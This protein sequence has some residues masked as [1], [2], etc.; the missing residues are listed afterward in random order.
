M[1]RVRSRPRAPRAPAPDESSAGNQEETQA[2]AAGDPKLC[3][4]P[5]GPHAE[6]GKFVAFPQPEPAGKKKKKPTR[7]PP[8]RAR[9]ACEKAA[10][11]HRPRGS[12]NCEARTGAVGLAAQDGFFRAPS[13]LPFWPLPRAPPRFSPG[14]TA[15]SWATAAQVQG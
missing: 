9:S 7:Q 8:W 5:K 11:P 12:G 1:P 13:F 3:L 10:P 6:L 14:R 15:R 4:D 2:N